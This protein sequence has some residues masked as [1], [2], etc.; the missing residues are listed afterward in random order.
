MQTMNVAI[1]GAGAIARSMCRTVRGMKEAGRPVE[2]Y[3]VASRSQEKADAF[4]KEQG[5][6]KAYGSYEAMLADPRVDLVYIATPHSHHAEQM[7][8]CIQYGKA[9]LC[10][11]AFTPNLRQAEEVLDLAREKGVYVA[12]AIWP[13]YMPSRWIINDLLAQGVIGEP[14][15]LYSNLCYAVENKERITDPNLAGGALLDL[16]VYVLNFASMVFGDDIVRINST[17]ELMDTGVDRTET[18]TIKY[19]DGRMAQLMASTAF[20][21]DR[22]C[23]VYGTKGYL[24]V[25]NV[26]NP[27]WVEIFDKDDRVHPIRRIDMPKQITGYEYEV[28]ACLRD[29]QA[30][31][32][33]PC[34]MPHEQTKMLLHQMDALRAIWHIKFPFEDKSP[35][36]DM[37]LIER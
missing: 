9:I 20:N 31:N 4:A 8:L 14:R 19:R 15:M 30:G 3:A 5:V 25:D 18:I 12:E 24:T 32:L 26:N 16:G 35:F 37:E 29:L 6:L 28:E 1:L 11:K 10:E 21:S 13:R 17:V 36:T 22:R 23:V 7:K 34:E 27:A 33:E 2:L